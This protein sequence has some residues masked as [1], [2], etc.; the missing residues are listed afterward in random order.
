MKTLNALWFTLRSL[1]LRGRVDAELD[2]ELAF[3]LD[4]E[5]A[6]HEQG[7]M[8]AAEAR[9]EAM[10]H[11]GGVQRV[12]EECRDVRR[13]SWLDDARAD[14]RFGLRLVRLYPGFSANVILISALGI[15]ACATTFSLV[16]GI[17]LT[18]LPFSAP[19]RVFELELKS[20]EGRASAA[21]PFDAYLR[22]AAGSRMVEA[23]AA[24][25]PSSMT[26]QWNDEPENA[27][28]ELVTASFFRAFGISP[29]VGR[30]FTVAEEEESAP[31][32]LLGYEMW[33]ARFNGDPAVVGTR[34]TLDG[35]PYTVIGVMPPHFRAHFTIE[36]ELWLPTH[37]G[38]ATVRADHDVNALIRLRDGVSQASAEAWLATVTR[39]RMESSTRKD[40]VAAWPSL[41]PIRDA[42]VGDVQRPLL[43]LLGAV[44]LVLALVAANVATMFLARSSARE[45]E[46][47]VRRAL[48]ASAGR[49]LRQ[50]V[51]ESATLTAIGGALGII[52][53][54]WAVGAI[55]GL[56]VR[57]LSRMDAVALDWRVLGFAVAGTMLTGIVGGLV[58]ALSTRRDSTSDMR[59]ASAAR[60]TGHRTSSSLVIAQITL[61]VVLL[62]G[63]G[64]LVKGFLRVLPTD[65]DFALENRATVS[66][67]L[68]GARAYPDSDRFAARRFVHDVSEGMRR[69]SG[70]REVAVTSFLPFTGMVSSTEID[71]PGHPAEGK[72]RRAYQNIITNN[73]FDVMRISLRRGRAFTAADNEGTG[74]VAIV[75]EAAASRWWPGEDPIGQQVTVGESGDV[76]SA[77]V[78]G[79][80][81][82]GRLFGNDTR[83]RPEI[84][85][86]IAQD[87]ARF[88]SF[89]VHTSVDPRSIAHDLKRAVWAAAPGLRISST[90]D[91]ATTA[92]NSVRR[93]RFFSWAM[94]VFA[95][96]AVALSAMAV[97]GLLSFA[98]VQ[99]R[100]EIGVRMAL[101]A[102]PGR[103]GALIIRRA[104][105]LGTTGVVLGVVL[106]RALTRYME[107]LLVEVTATDATIFMTTAVVVLAVA[108]IAACAPMY[109]A[110]RVD[111]MESLRA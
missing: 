104:L 47:G 39:A 7:G 98:V 96:V 29:I 99:R 23:V 80:A 51:T 64:L 22:I 20:V 17:L 110:T 50:L 13:V 24:Y 44:L 38:T 77:T 109:Q 9:R 61:S 105:V 46:L 83:I 76:F 81:R 3:H 93:A 32:V 82:G 40:S 67:E 8:T 26:V 106:A 102:T 97:Y 62:V 100:R 89:V 19:N 91:L 107:S 33:T 72:A 2:E 65:A 66:F 35:A 108:V 21:F 16:S 88:L 12:R 57:V 92:S 71:I 69:V 53:S 15:A 6:M 56:G 55:R 74:R 68:R 31:V 101:G 48:G 4:R 49:Q 59:D 18:P 103:I 34:L 84:F 41:A 42:I 54:Y 87:K 52:V 94:G 14:V 1:V 45:R 78:V 10:R 63:A 43:V 85:L 90:T 37:V 75:N 36:P 25:R 95:A 11:F 60:V 27:R 58:P 70:V 86:P 111:P 30:A 79:V 28:A 5:T 73:Y